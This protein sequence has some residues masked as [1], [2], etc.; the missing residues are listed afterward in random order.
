MLKRTL[1]EAKAK[2][3]AAD[4]AWKKARLDWGARRVSSRV[5]REAAARASSA[6]GAVIKAAYEAENTADGS[7]V[8][9]AEA[10]HAKDEASGESQPL[11]TQKPLDTQEVSAGQPVA[12]SP[13]ASASAASGALSALASRGREQKNDSSLTAAASGAPSASCGVFSTAPAVG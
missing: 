6:R 4:A 9:K 7:V 3:D 2:A 12:F 10:E 13:A 11:H 5:V 1:D 8:A